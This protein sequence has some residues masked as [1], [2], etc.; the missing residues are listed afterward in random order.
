VYAFRIGLKALRFNIAQNN[1]SR[2]QDCYEKEENRDDYN[3]H[4][5]GLVIMTELRARRRILYKKTGLS[6]N[7]EIGLGQVR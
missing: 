4:E 5:I 3:A 2:T 7:T 6:K 1:M